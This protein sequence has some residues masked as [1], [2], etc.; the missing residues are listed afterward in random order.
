MPFVNKW[1]KH[2]AI[3]MFKCGHNFH[4]RCVAANKGNCTI[5][6]NEHDEISK[7]SFCSQ[8]SFTFIFYRENHTIEV[9]AQQPDDRCHRSS[10]HGSATH[11]RVRWS[12]HG[13]HLWQRR[14]GRR[15]RGGIARAVQQEER[16]SHRIEGRG[17]ATEE[18]RRG[19]GGQPDAL[20]GDAGRAAGAEPA[21]EEVP[22]VRVC[23]DG[24]RDVHRS[25]HVKRTR[26]S[27]RPPQA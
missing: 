1:D 26:A 21:R 10:R 23:D 2:H 5:C 19:G 8:L 22:D 14:G 27:W 6:F 12:P 4:Q 13:C 17:R 18:G 20:R 11:Q 9:E 25:L 24:A 7:Y 16:R 15:R 3:Q